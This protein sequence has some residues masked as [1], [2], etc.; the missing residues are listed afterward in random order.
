MPS[1]VYPEENEPVATDSTTHYVA[2]STPV[3]ASA[4]IPDAVFDDSEDVK[5]HPPSPV[6][7]TGENAAKTKATDSKAAKEEPP[8][9]KF[10][11]SQLYR[12]ATTG[13][14][15]ALGF[16]LV[17]T[18]I[19]GALFPCMALIFGEA[20]SS[21][22]PYDQDRVNN[23]ALLYLGVALILFATDY[24]S[25]VLFHA[26][27]ERQIKALREAGLRHMLFLDITWYDKHDAL[28]LSSR[29][30]GD[31]VKIMDGMGQK[32]GDSIRFTAQFIAGYA[33]GF[34]KGW[35]I[36]LVMACVMPCI[37]MSLA[38]MLKTLRARSEW[39]QKVYAEAGAIAEE[40]LGS[41]RTVVSN[42]GEGR[43]I[44]KYNAKALKAEAENIKLARLVSIVMGVFFGSMWLMYAAGLWY[45][46]HRVAQAKSDPG[47]VFSAFFGILIGSI[48]MAQISPNLTA[49][50]Q[51][52]GA[53]AG[54][55]EILGTPS[56]IDASKAKEGVVP[57]SCVGRIEARNLHFS[58]PSRPEVTILNNYSVTI[59][60]GQTVAF[61]GA[62]GG[63]KSTLISLLERFYD[64]SS[65]EI[66]LDGRDIKTLNLKWLRSQI[67]LVSQEPVLFA[68]TVL[69]NIAF[70]ATNVTRE[71][72]E[73]AARLAN[74]HDFIMRLPQGYDTL[75]GEKGVSLSGGQKQR[76]AIARAVVRNPKILVLDEAT[77]AL[78]NESERVVQAALNDL[79][80]KTNMTT[81]V[82]AHRLSTI[83]DVD[84]IVVLQNGAVAEEGNHDELMKLPDGLYRNL[85][86]IQA[87]N[88]VNEEEDK[89]DEVSDA[90]HPSTDVVP[91]QDERSKSEASEGGATT[92]LDEVVGNEVEASNSFSLR[93][94]FELCRPERSY[95]VIGCLAAA[96]VGTSM[97]ASSVLISGLVGAMTEKYMF[98]QIT[99]DKSYLDALY[100]QVQVYGALYVGG[101]FLLLIATAIQQYCFKYMA[102]KLTSRLRDYHFTALCR[103]NIGFFDETAHAT[104]ALTADL[105]TNATKV[106]MLS[107]DAQGRVIQAVFTFIA[108]LAISFSLGSWLLSLVMLAV[109]PLLI[110]GQVA[111]MQ[112]M[113]G[114]GG[115]TDEL[116]ESGAHASQALS[117][118]RTVVSLGLEERMMGTYKE[119]LLRP[120]AKGT[121]AAHVNGAAL[122]FSSFIVFAV[123]SLVFWYGG[124]L[125]SKNDISFQQLMRTLMAIMMSSQG[126]GAAASWLADSDNAQRSGTAIFDLV[127][128]KLS[129][130]SFAGDGVR[131]DD[132]Q[133][134][135]D[136]QNISFRYPTRPQVT[137]LRRYNLTIEAGQ[138]VAFCG[139]SGGGKS[140]CIALIERFYDPVKGN[141]LLDGHDLKSLNLQWLRSQIGL[142]GQEPTLFIGSIAENI[143][144]GLETMPCQ[145]E[146]EAAA[147]MANAHDYISR[148]P[149]GY[150]TQVGMKGEQ[151]S[152][153]Q[154]QRIAIA[155]AILK[156]PKILLLDEATSALD[157]ESEKVVQEA[158]DKVLSLQ[159]RTTI[160]IAHRLST[161]RKADKI[162]VVSGGR[163]AEQ[164]THSELLARPDGIYARLVAKGQ[165]NSQ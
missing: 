96:F 164:G 151:L 36:S 53:A 73:N 62:S 109:F 139:P 146:I 159:K 77:S 64:P 16:G 68:T 130:D 71:D 114:G 149:D 99:K 20:I 133:G 141:V 85:Y 92:A 161:I 134:R 144:Y 117:N 143:A 147:K 118:I 163:I 121:R 157:S 69:G 119:M 145:E 83:R 35:D 90:T 70:G 37:A 57:D 104:G 108:A 10:K 116:G 44:D 22:Q 6:I 135:L 98:Y 107:G 87:G 100:D 18:M 47:S 49:V 19:N 9:A 88:E 128:R 138:T 74:A 11:F 160:I 93:K 56:T 136:F 79:M 113:K 95:F 29:L 84:K 26:T 60:S 148:F 154:K 31:T 61:V 33:I 58:Y 165:G 129:I 28:Q 126:I 27:A 5:T 24:L 76:I 89:H 115:G 55:Y 23:A 75:V 45:G 124:K 81:L 153:G 39:A 105:A 123:Y 7:V 46:G 8:K 106:G 42:N 32:L 25:Y 131:L 15:I 103:Q 111:R 2:V 34:S 14:F 122:G 86:T 1:F 140:T 72:A 21:F 120:M 51:A 82:I 155:R 66:L 54:L 127:E 13:D 63:G 142:V 43:A 40:T 17:M 125:V 162:C 137:V 80:A 78:D 132:V 50:A 101:A 150:S 59:E 3:G 91:F 94:A 4:S 158:L 52:K 38:F 67:G 110:I 112:H 65:G 156:N 41:M 102:E 12:Y 30:N 152:G 97:P 48:S